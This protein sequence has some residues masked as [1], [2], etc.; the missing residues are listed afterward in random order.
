[1]GGSRDNY[2]TFCTELEKAKQ[3][4]SIRS[5]V[6]SLFLVL[7]TELAVCVCIVCMCVQFLYFFDTA[8]T[9][10]FPVSPAHGP[11]SVK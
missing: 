8:I 4:G 9:H 3:S 5:A 10:N 7:Y 6:I 2:R 11:G 1:M